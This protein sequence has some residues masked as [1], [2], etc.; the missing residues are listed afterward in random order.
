MSPEARMEHLESIVIR[1][2][3]ASKKQKTAILNR[4]NAAPYTLAGTGTLTGTSGQ[5]PPSS[6]GLRRAGFV[7]KRA[8]CPSRSA[9]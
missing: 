9:N 2:H 3:K 4:E 8:V 7:L 1:Y 6:F 5:A